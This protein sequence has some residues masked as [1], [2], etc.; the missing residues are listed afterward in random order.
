[1]ATET[2]PRQFEY[3]DQP[4]S[5]VINAC[6]EEIES[7]ANMVDAESAPYI[8]A[9]PETTA[10]I[11]HSVYEK[12]GDSPVA[13]AYFDA[14]APYTASFVVAFENGDQAL[15]RLDSSLPD[16]DTKATLSYIYKDEA[17]ASADRQKH[18]SIDDTAVVLQALDSVKRDYA[19]RK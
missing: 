8:K 6:V 18:M 2:A 10:E 13:S 14:S 5:E 12:S 9:D 15:Y 11:M 3:P 16:A 17:T 19:A 4:N 7:L 1:M